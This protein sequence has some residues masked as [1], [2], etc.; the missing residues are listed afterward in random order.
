MFFIVGLYSSDVAKHDN[1]TV[2]ND[3]CDSSSNLAY[4]G[5]FLICIIWLCGI[6]SVYM[7]S[8]CLAVH[9]IIS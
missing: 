4:P 3:L 1:M 5:M 6:Q 7:Q 9:A 8:V 2:T